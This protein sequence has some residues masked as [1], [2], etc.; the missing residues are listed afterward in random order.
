MN[1]QERRQDIYNRVKAHLLKQGQRASIAGEGCMYRLVLEDGTVLKCAIGGLI[2]DDKYDPKWEG[3]AAWGLI[4]KQ[5]FRDATGF[6]TEDGGAGTGFAK[7][8]Q[9]IHDEWTPDH[10]EEQLR[11][12]AHRFNLQP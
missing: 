5:S 1:T 4:S 12:L 7:Q 8:L 3:K 9:E 11:D 2:P 6:Y 10:W